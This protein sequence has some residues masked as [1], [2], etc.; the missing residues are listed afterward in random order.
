M[1][2]YPRMLSP[3]LKKANAFQFM[4]H[5]LEHAAKFFQ[6]ESLHRLQRNFFERLWQAEQAG[7]LNPYPDDAIFHEQID[8]LISDMN[9]HPLHGLRFLVAAWVGCL[10]RREHKT[11]SEMLSSAGGQELAFRLDT[12]ARCWQFSAAARSALL[13]LSERDFA[14]ADALCIEDELT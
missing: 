3:V 6:D 9:T 5:D 14:R 12:L 4:V 8:Y 1:A 2:Q 13:R 11:A 10:L 7:L